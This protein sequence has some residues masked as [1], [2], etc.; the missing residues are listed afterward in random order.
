MS[1]ALGAAA[2]FLLD[3][4]F[5]EPPSPVHPVAWFGRAMSAA[6]RWMWGDDRLRGALFTGLGVLPAAGA[7]LGLRRI[8]GPGLS[9]TV[10]ATLSIAG[11]MLNR[12]AIEVSD[13][14]GNGDLDAARA[15]LPTL[16]G[17]DPSRLDHPEVARAAI[18]SVA[19]NTIDAVIAPLWWGAIAGAPGMFAHRTINT[20]DAMVGHRTRRH[21]RFGWAS[22]RL[23]D[24]AN[25]WPARLGVIA[26]MLARPGRSAT[27]RST[28]RR[29]AGRHP[30]PNA[31]PIEAAYA[32]ALDVELGGSNVYRGVTEHRGRL[33]TGAAPTA[34]DIH[35]A[36]AL[37]RRSSTLV[38]AS[39]A[40]AGVLWLRHA[41]RRP[42]HRAPRT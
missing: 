7:G 41:A 37:A 29:D 5:G 19:E 33:G 32:A 35:R 13:A 8:L 16:V 1:Q 6:E 27:V 39:T 9:T 24:L 22:A 18:E 31:G 40:A 17:R 38:A 25:W 28:V 23:D 11:R 12:G 36:V 30:S 42:T 20:L 21:H 34:V 15:L 4:R 3:R 2:G 26:V 10:A 14:L